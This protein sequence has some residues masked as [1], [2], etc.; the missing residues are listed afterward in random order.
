MAGSFD[1]TAGIG[2][3]YFSQTFRVDSLLTDTLEAALALSDTYFDDLKGKIQL[4]YAP[5]A[6][7]SML[8]SARLEQSVDDFRLRA[9]L[10]T[11]FTPGR[12]RI[13]AEQEFDLR[14][15]HQSTDENNRSY[16]YGSS[17]NRI[18]YSTG[19]R[20]NIIGGLRGDI[21]RFSQTSQYSRDYHRLGGNIGYQGGFGT[22]SSY[23]VNLFLT[24]REV[25]DS[26]E[27][28]YTNTGADAS[29]FW[30]REHGETEILTQWETKDYDQPDNQD[31]F[32]R[33]ELLVQNRSAYDNS[34]AFKQLL[35]LE[36]VSFAGNGLFNFDY[37][38]L[39]ATVLIG[40]QSISGSIIGGPWAEWLMEHGDQASEALIGTQDFRELGV[41][42]EVDYMS[43]K[44]G[45]IS[46]Q[47]TIGRQT[48]TGEI[49][50]ESDFNFIRSD[51]LLDNPILGG[52]KAS[53]LLSSEWEYHENRSENIR[54]ILFSG[55]LN[56]SF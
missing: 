38:K 51:L 12:W 23:S 43:P 35:E 29:V 44:V 26:V 56:Y 2:Y 24:Y 19:S 55:G 25:P 15:D 37:T 34:M 46:L 50:A 18:Y 32:T 11:N 49:P 52:L 1:V 21:V 17:R 6:R 20:S 54:I 16:W 28:N 36:S 39:S 48:L 3:D 53:V 7:R 10:M 40:Y 13:L 14:N 8:L 9:G 30:L 31:D 33:F 22:Y 27:W 5:G 4:E 41:R 42:V 45:Y 47:T